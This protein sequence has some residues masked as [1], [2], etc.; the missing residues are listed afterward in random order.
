MIQHSHTPAHS[1]I[2]IIIVVIVLPLGLSSAEARLGCRVSALYPRT[3]RAEFLFSVSGSEL[4]GMVSSRDHSFYA[5]RLSPAFRSQGS[6][7]AS[8]SHEAEIA[9]IGT[10]RPGCFH[11]INARDLSLVGYAVPQERSERAGL[12]ASRGRGF[13][14][15]GP[16]T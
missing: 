15:S 7:G 10:E 1:T 16:T 12:L 4:R 14:S 13:R 5:R 6:L 11:Q 8:A 3:H 9:R 2:A